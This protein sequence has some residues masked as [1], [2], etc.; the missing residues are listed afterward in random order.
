MV[1]SPLEKIAEELF[2]EWLDAARGKE[3]VARDS[4][5]ARAGQCNCQ[6]ILERKF[7][8][9]DILC[10][11]FLSPGRALIPG[12]LLGDYQLVRSLGAGSSG[13]VWEAEQLSLR[14]RV[15]L[16][17]FHPLVALSSR[18]ESRLLR[19]AEA[20]ARIRHP[21][22]VAVFGVGHEEGVDFLV[23]ELI[24]E[25]RTLSNWFADESFRPLT[26]KKQCQL[27]EIFEELASA[28]V[29]AHGE[30]I[31]H[32]DIKPAN[33]LLTEEGR[34][35]LADFGLA[36]LLNEEFQTE[37]LSRA[38]TLPY[39]PPEVLHDQGWS[40]ASDI[41][42]LGASLFEVLFQR[43]PFSGDTPAALQR[44]ILEGNLVLSDM[45]KAE[46]EPE[47]QAITLRALS[48]DPGHRYSDMAAF[49]ADL[50]AFRTGR[51]VAAKPPS[52]WTRLQR[53]CARY[54]WRTAAFGLALFSMLC[55][56]WMARDNYFERLR[57][58]E[59]LLALKKT[60]L[61]TQ[62]FVDMISPMD[63]NTDQNRRQR[64]SLLQQRQL[65]L[66]ALEDDPALQSRV[67]LGVG[68]GLIYLE[69]FSEAEVTLKTALDLC[70]Q[71]S[72]LQDMPILDLEL[73]YAWAL[74]R[75]RE[76]EKA[77]PILRRLAT[78]KHTTGAA[79][80]RRFW[81]KNRLGQCLLDLHSKN[82][83][84][85]PMQVH[86]ALEA[87]V[88]LQDLLEE[89]A[90][91]DIHLDGPLLPLT[92][93][94]LGLVQMVLD[95]DESAQGNLEEARHLYLSQYGPNHPELV[96]VAIALSELAFKRN[97]PREALKMLDDAERLASRIHPA[98]HRAWQ[99]VKY[100]TVKSLEIVEGPEAALLL[101]SELLEL[102]E[103]TLD[104]SIRAFV[105]SSKE[106]LLK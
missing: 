51:S 53:W 30:G 23:T 106:K 87:E 50:Q 18:S 63:V 70:R 92:L 29:V 54:P 93:L 15:A 10:Q 76:Q 55:F 60:V 11:R 65:C 101:I 5:L 28:L 43:T 69:N 68:K 4:F 36:L 52:V 26:K 22:V 39:T 17:V 56:A 7:N 16:K 102:P 38:G 84:S 61:Y 103:G 13:S 58:G 14:R 35:K 37:S 90:A 97:H 80:V 75:N 64:E 98:H 40:E 99:E 59:A 33:I 74:S 77:L 67:L 24:S 32:R 100:Q 95:Q 94:D 46:S 57:A 91:S 3:F 45:E 85:H 78:A 1:N 72:S 44:N 19:E 96:Y 105:E 9:F 8:D 31:L 88:V 6:D 81:A 27:T 42:S 48:H 104:P 2:Q 62:D 41:Y 20:A 34:P 66:N 73:L 82:S 49:A 86:L 47:L 71:N 79:E 83:E 25:G 21:A 12:T 89:L